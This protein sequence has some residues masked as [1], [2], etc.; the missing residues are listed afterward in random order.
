VVLNKELEGAKPSTVFTQYLERFGSPTSGILQSRLTVIV[1][2]TLR[3]Q[4]ISTWQ[5]LGHAAV[6]HLS[7][8]RR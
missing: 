1:A 5:N 8:L 4:I 6:S 2:A 7:L 3:R